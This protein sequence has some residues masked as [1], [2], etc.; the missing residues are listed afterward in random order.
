MVGLAAVNIPVGSLL[1]N[2][3][4]LPNRSVAASQFE[5]PR[6]PRLAGLIGLIGSTPT[7]STTSI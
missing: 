1:F 5:R 4:A 6:K 2:D 7:A 3:T